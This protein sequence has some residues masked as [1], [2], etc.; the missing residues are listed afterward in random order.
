MKRLYLYL[1][2]TGLVFLLLAGCEAAPEEDPVPTF[3]YGQVQAFYGAEKPGV[4]RHG[5]ENC[6]AGTAETVE[7]AVSL[8][9][10][11]CTVSYDAVTVAYDPEMGMWRVSFLMQS[12]AGGDQTIYLDR[13][14]RIR[15]MVY[16]E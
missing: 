11:A 7:E 8:A 14:G 6:T 16:G 3:S 9:E 4:I 13:S 10:K 12:S 1:L 2:A 15:L 5:F